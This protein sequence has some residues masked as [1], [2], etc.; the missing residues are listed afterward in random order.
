MRR[1]DHPS[2][3]RAITCCFFSSLKTLLMSREPIRALLG[4]NV[5]GFPM[6]GFQVTLY[7][8]IWV[9][10]EV[11]F[12]LSVGKRLGPNMPRIC[13]AANPAHPI[14]VAD[15]SKDITS[16]GAA[17]FGKARKSKRLHPHQTGL[18][19]QNLRLRDRATQWAHA[20]DQYHEVADLQFRHHFQ[21]RGQT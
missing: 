12:A 11:V 18:P 20:S 1:K 21:T 8:R 2:F 9:T 14:L 3:P 10:P 17:I 7:G 6:A 4:V 5:P 19:R 13:F 16:V 15:L